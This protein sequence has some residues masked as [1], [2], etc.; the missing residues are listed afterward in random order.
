MV[1]QGQFTEM[2]KNYMVDIISS[3][4]FYLVISSIGAATPSVRGVVWDHFNALSD[5]DVP[6]FLDVSQTPVD[7]ESC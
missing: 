1:E 5:G 4:V 7:T 3:S 6:L 2:Q